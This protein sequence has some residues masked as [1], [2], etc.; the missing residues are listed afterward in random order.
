[1]I[2]REYVIDVIYCIEIALNFL[3]WSNA[4]NDVYKIATKYLK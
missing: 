3:K 1:M 4:Y 2:Q